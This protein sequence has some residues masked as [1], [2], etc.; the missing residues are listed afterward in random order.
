MG[1]ILK[2][3]ALRYIEIDRYIDRRY[4]QPSIYRSNI[5]RSQYL[6]IVPTLLCTSLSPIKFHDP[7]GYIKRTETGLDNVSKS[8]YSEH[9]NG[10]S[11]RTS[12]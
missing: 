8:R 12:L 2:N 4:H 5:D 10:K 7:A 11:I 3:I 1:D 9:G 6:H